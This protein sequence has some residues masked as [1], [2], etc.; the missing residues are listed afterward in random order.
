[1]IIRGT[2][3]DERALA[4]IVPNAD[5][6]TKS[7]LDQYIVIIEELEWETGEVIPVADYVKYERPEHSWMI[8]YGCNKG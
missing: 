4:W 1:V 5:D 6:A 8:P 2:G 7:A 3:E